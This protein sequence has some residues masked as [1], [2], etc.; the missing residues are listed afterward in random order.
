VAELREPAQRVQREHAR[1]R[2]E[3]QHELLLVG[4]DRC[5]GEAQPHCGRRGGRGSSRDGGR[6]GGGGDRG[7]GRDRQRG[8]GVA[9]QTRGDGTR[10]GNCEEAAGRVRGLRLCAD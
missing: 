4:R 5:A 3:L 7:G 2:I 6:A 1:N 8:G 10:V 9:G